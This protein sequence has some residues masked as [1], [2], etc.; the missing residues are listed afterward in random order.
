M[1]SQSTLRALRERSIFFFRWGCN[2]HFCILILALNQ[3][4]A[5][6]KNVIISNGQRSKKSATTHSKKI[7]RQPNS[8]TFSSVDVS[9]HAP[10]HV[11]RENSVDSYCVI[12]AR[13]NFQFLPN[14]RSADNRGRTRKKYNEGVGYHSDRETSKLI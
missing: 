13:L 12:N 11:H 3:M 2:H 4:N 5:Y 6:T 8:E 14:R 9:H 1:A 7:L 10:G